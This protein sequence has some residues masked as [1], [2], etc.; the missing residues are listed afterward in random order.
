MWPEIETNIIVVTTLVVPPAQAG[1]NEIILHH[2]YKPP[3]KTG[4]NKN[5]TILRVLFKNKTP[6]HIGARVQSR[7]STQFDLITGHLW[8]PITRPSV[9][10]TWAITLS[11]S[12]SQ[13]VFAAFAWRKLSASGFLSLSG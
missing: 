11:G 8:Q 9:H 13:G 12:G 2:N 10:H 5:E 6:A 3:P 7:G 4:P 1:Y